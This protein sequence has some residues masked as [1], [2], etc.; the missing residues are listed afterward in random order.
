MCAVEDLIYKFLVQSGFPRA[1]IVT[2][3]TA[4]LDD[5]NSDAA[6]FVI[7]DPQNTDRL[8]VLQVVGPIDAETLI[9]Q[10][11]LLAQVASTIG[12]R[13]TQ[14][15][16]IRVDLK[17]KSDAEQVQFYRCH[18]NAELQQVT[19]R[20]FPD[21]DSLKVSYK[22]MADKS[23]GGSV[24]EP[25][26]VEFVEDDYVDAPNVGIGAA[27]PGIALLLLALADW[28]LALFKGIELFNVTQ[29]ILLVGA[30]VLLSLPTIVRYLRN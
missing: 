2:D 30:A 26:I 20:T 7:V 19:A 3:V 15:F 1:S 18:P 13:Q 6:S 14:G 11:A 23:V 21:F 5:A 16:V 12:G 10:S 29:A 28:A 8:A 25:E 24:A 17:A 27:L 4:I 9:D 22:L